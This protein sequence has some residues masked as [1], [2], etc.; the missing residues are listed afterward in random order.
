M[1]SRSTS[2][3]QSKQI[4]PLHPNVAKKES[5]HPAHRPEPEQQ[6]GFPGFSAIPSI[7]EEYSNFIAFVAP[8]QY[9]VGIRPSVC[10][11]KVGQKLWMP[12]WHSGL[13][14]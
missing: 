12:G 11:S 13:V 1:V 6:Y 3:D 14:C 5:F 10:A 8:L 7:Y 9:R 4:R 2:L